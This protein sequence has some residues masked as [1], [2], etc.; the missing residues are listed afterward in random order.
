[1]D[2]LFVRFWSYGFGKQL[3]LVLDKMPNR[4]MANT[5]SNHLAADDEPT[6]ESVLQEMK[7]L[8]MML[9][10]LVAELEES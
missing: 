8:S 3:S 9:D 1:M 6:K 5:V 7:D 10:G 2:S 4:L